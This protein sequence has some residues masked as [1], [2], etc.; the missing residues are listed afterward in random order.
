MKNIIKTQK[1]EK[2]E[3]YQKQKNIGRRREVGNTHDSASSG[4]N[5]G[6]LPEPEH[7]WKPYNTTLAP[8]YYY[9][10]ACSNKRRIYKRKK[11][12][13]LFLPELLD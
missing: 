7:N 6:S 2:V 13:S 5:P 11:K 4:E 8:C 3:K 9:W 12:G 10:C 1:C